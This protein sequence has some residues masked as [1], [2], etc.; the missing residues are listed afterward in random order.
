MSKA[1]TLK[2]FI[3]QIGINKTDCSKWIM[4]WIRC[5]SKLIEYDTR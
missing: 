1:A 5:K 4:S 2:Q 3:H